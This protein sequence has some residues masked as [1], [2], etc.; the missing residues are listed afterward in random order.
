MR[1][2]TL[3]SVLMFLSM[4]LFLTMAPQRSHAQDTPATDP[5]APTSMDPNASPPVDPNAPPPVDPGA[6]ADPNAPPETNTN[7]PPSLESG[8]VPPATIP[9]PASRPFT[10]RFGGIELGLMAGALVAGW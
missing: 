7:P 6:P 3:R 4:S 8:E 5:N 10:A 9:P 2:M 1:T